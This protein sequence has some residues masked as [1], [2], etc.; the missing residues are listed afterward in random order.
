MVA[1]LGIQRIQPTH[2][3]DNALE[4]YH[5]KKHQSHELQN[6]C[7]GHSAHA[8]CA[9]IQGGDDTYHEHALVH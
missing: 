4:E 3:V 9:S 7:D 8:A 2:M 1:Q 6:V 5:H